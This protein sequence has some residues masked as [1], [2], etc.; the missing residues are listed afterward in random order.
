MMNKTE[1]FK[2]YFDS[3]KSIKYCTKTQSKVKTKLFFNFKLSNR[4]KRFSKYDLLIKSHWVINSSKPV[5]I[6][7][8]KESKAFNEFK[9]IGLKIDRLFK[10]LLNM[11]ECMFSMDLN[12]N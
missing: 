2:N 7:K 9:V 12:L 6:N 4:P 1:K 11:E 3:I 10:E 8:L 5:K